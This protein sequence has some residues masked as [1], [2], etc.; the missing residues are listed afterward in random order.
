MLKLGVVK[1]LL[2][3]TLFV[4]SFFAQ[5]RADSY[6]ATYA[7]K[8]GKN[9]GVYTSKSVNNTTAK[10]STKKAL[11]LGAGLDAYYA[12]SNF[13]FFCPGDSFII[14]IESRFESFDQDVD[15]AN[16][17]SDR[18]FKFTCGFLEDSQ[19]RLI[20]KINCGTATFADTNKEAAEKE[21]NACQGSAKFFDGLAG[22][23]WQKEAG[24]FYN[25][26][27]YTS[28]CCQL[29]DFDGKILQ[30]TGECSYFSFKAG[31]NFSFRCGPNQILKNMGIFAHGALEGDAFTFA[32]CPAVSP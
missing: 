15:A 26:R 4:S 2:T 7:S 16:H 8:Y 14:G 17:S 10:L 30:A 27:E 29:N 3:S 11:A 31:K 13:D 19:K 25:N 12:K 1:T 28:S 23:R 22:K 24:T 5:A 6:P 21:A 20:R 9:Q 18:D 32:C